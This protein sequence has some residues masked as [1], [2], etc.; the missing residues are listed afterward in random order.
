MDDADRAQLIWTQELLATLIRRMAGAKILSEHGADAL[1]EELR[2]H[3][4]Q[5]YPEHAGRFLA[6]AAYL[7]TGIREE[8]DRNRDAGR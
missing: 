1:A 6:H 3:L 5:K 8:C 4:A 2:A 7:Q